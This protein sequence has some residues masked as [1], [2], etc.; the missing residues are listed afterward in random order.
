MKSAGSQ[1]SKDKFNVLADALGDT[2]FTVGS[3][4]ALCRRRCNAYVSGTASEPVATV[5]QSH[6]CRTEPTGFGADPELLWDLLMMVDGW[7]CFLVDSGCSHSVAE[8]MRQHTER[9]V[10]FIHEINFR[11]DSPVKRYTN[12]SVRLLTP[13]DV[14]LLDSAPEEVAQYKD[15]YPDAGEYLAEA[16]VAAAI[17]DGVIVSIARATGWS[18]RHV[19]VGVDTLKP[20]RRRGFARAAASLV[21]SRIQEEGQIPVWSTGHFNTASLKIAEQLGFVEIPRRTYVVTDK[22]VTWRFAE[23]DY[24]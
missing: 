10:G 3:I 6:D 20:Y 11:L 14:N 13:K 24:L 21:T 12:P 7:D 23:H 19:D 5:I 8:L 15:E 18:E 22:T 4:H 2:P 1:L 9:Q 17:V 16:I